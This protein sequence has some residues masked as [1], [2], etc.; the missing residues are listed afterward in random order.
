MDPKTPPEERA[1]RAKEPDSGSEALPS[2]ADSGSRRRRQPN[3]AALRLLEEWL[4]DE[5]GYDEQTWPELKQA[6]EENRSSGRR[7]F[8]D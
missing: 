6:L 4:N 7:L 8:C 1:L 2:Q 5:S 3:R